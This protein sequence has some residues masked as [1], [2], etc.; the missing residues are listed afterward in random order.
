MTKAS[1]FR[2][3]FD[4]EKLITNIPLTTTMYYPKV[5]VGIIGPDITSHSIDGPSQIKLRLSR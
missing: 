3:Q 1:I 2:K 4:S 5:I